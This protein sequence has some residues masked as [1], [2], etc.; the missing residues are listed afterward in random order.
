M[1]RRSIMEIGMPKPLTSPPHDPVGSPEEPA[2]LTPAECEALLR[3]SSVGRI[4][5]VVEGWPVV[6]PVNYAFDGA[7]VVLRTDARSRLAA[8]T[9]GHDA[10]VALEVDAPVAVFKSGWSVLA[11]GMASEITDHDDVARL[12]TLALEPWARGIREHWIRV[13]LVQM[14]GR[15]L[16]EQGRYPNPVR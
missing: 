13:H 8:A 7:D 11:H 6:I 10:Q 2:V 5:Y 15:R 16:G 1:N 12:R 3:R 9:R 14:T 4:A